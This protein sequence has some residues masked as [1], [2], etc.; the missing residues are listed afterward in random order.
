MKSGAPSEEAVGSLPRSIGLFP[1]IL[2]YP[3]TP[4]LI[5]H[6]F[7]FNIR[8]NFNSLERQMWSSIVRI[9]AQCIF[10]ETNQQPYISASSSNSER[11]RRMKIIEEGEGKESSEKR[12]AQIK[13]T[14]ETIIRSYR[15]REEKER[16][17][18]EI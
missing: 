5:N 8:M 7:F 4:K 17:E 9:H 18:E 6:R 1:R 15:V 16:R 10:D 13:E 12:L 11:P 3:V 2:K 14:A